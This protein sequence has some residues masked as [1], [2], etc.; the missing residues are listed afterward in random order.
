MADGKD[1]GQVMVETQKKQSASAQT[2]STSS[3]S[4]LPKP[5]VDVSSLLKTEKM[6]GEN[7]YDLDHTE[8]I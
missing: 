4:K 7:D 5:D 6:K 2:I 8:D 3:S 1:P